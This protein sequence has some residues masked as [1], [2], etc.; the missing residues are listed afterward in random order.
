MT[1]RF[2][3]MPRATV[4]LL[5]GFLLTYSAHAASPSLTVI[6]NFTGLNGDVTACA[7]DQ[8][9]LVLNLQR[10][11]FEFGEIRIH[12][13]WRLPRRPYLGSRLLRDAKH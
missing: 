6:Y 13:K 1:S 12:W 5:A 3:N 7:C 10:L 2:Y 9:N 8:I 4:L 11:D